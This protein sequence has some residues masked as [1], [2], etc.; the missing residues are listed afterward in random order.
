MIIKSDEE[1]AQ[2]HE[3]LQPRLQHL[4]QLKANK[5]IITTDDYGTLEEDVRKYL[6]ALLLDTEW[7]EKIS[8]ITAFILDNAEILYI[9]AEAPHTKKSIKLFLTNYF[10]N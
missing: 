6:V 10:N 3:S 8:E 9:F 7:F 5:S 2:I 4:Y 1:I